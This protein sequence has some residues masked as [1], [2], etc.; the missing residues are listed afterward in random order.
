MNITTL[1]N[2]KP[3]LLVSATKL[4]SLVLSNNRQEIQTKS[5]LLRKRKEISKQRI[6]TFAGLQAD[7][8][9]GDIANNALL[10]GGL[11]AGGGLSLLRGKQSANNIRPVSYTHLTLPTKRIV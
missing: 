10:G 9:R 4:T 3:S 6:R 5:L 2:R 11:A 8:N 1:L 7:A